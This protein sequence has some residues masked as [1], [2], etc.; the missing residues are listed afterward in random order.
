MYLRVFWC[1]LGLGCVGGA[2]CDS[3]ESDYLISEG[4]LFLSQ[5]VMGPTS[6]YFMHL[7]CD[8]WAV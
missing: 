4:R 5:E 8:G 3:H 1:G 7:D 6:F 2:R